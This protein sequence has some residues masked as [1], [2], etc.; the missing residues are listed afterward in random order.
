M[1]KTNRFF[2]KC[3]AL[4]LTLCVLIGAFPVSVSAAESYALSFDYDASKGTVRE[5]NK[6]TTYE[7]GKLCYV[8]VYPNTGYA[9]DSVRV[10]KSTGGNVNITTTSSVPLSS[11]ARAYG[12]YMPDCSVTVTATFKTNTASGYHD[13]T[14]HTANCSGYTYYVSGET[15][16]VAKQGERLMVTSVNPNWSAVFIEMYYITESGDRVDM[17]INYEYYMPNQN[18]DVYIKCEIEYRIYTDGTNGC[19]Y[20]YPESSSIYS[21]SRSLPGERVY[22]RG[23]SDYNGT[24]DPTFIVVTDGDLTLTLDSSNS[25][26][27]PRDNVHI[28]AI[29]AEK[30]CRITID[31]CGHGDPISLTVENGTNFFDALYNAGTFETLDGMSDENYR[32]RDITTKPLSQFS[33]EE[34][35]TNNAYDLLSSNVTKSM[36][37]YAGFYECVRNVTVTVERPI[38]GTQ[39]SFDEN[40]YTQ[41]PEPVVTVSD[42]SHCYLYQGVSVCDENGAV[43]GAIEPGKYYTTE[44]LLMSDFGYW[45]DSDI[46]TVNVIG[47]TLEDASG[48]MALFVSAKTR[49]AYAPVKGDC[50]GDGKVNIGDV[51]AIQRHLAEIEPLTGD[52]LAAAD[53][54]GDGTVTID[55]A[56]AIQSYLAEFENVYGLG[57]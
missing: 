53:V 24:G 51:T 10:T 56:T 41:T 54:N 30:Y 20:A 11:D 23:R 14:F 33:D 45:L 42:G 39:Y 38:V 55:D 46:T 37:V 35:Y 26:I 43:N 19:A 6:A 4:A 27:M 29:Y 50:N 48:A 7:S 28:Y 44:F 52:F 2:A 12:F 15:R 5:Q 36:T 31:L 8:L 13:I 3:L 25:F 49:S 57:A 32:F 21:I 17:N 22:V 1:K 9:I 16:T 47:G 34:T 40:N 18:I